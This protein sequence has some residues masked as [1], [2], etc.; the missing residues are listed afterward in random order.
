[1]NTERVIEVGDRQQEVLSNSSN[2][3]LM[4]PTQQS[5]NQIALQSLVENGNKRK[6]NIQA[7]K[8]KVSIW[9]RDP[10][11]MFNKFDQRRDEITFN[12]IIQI[13]KKPPEQRQ[14][15]EIFKLE[16]YF[17]NNLF[18]KN[19][20][21][22]TDKET[23]YHCYK[24]MN[25][26]IFQPGET[27]FYYGDIG[28]LFYIILRGEVA[29]KIPTA[30]DLEISPD[31]LFIFCIQYYDDIEWQKF[32]SSENIRSEIKSEINRFGINY[33]NIKEKILMIQD[34]MRKKEFQIPF[35]INELL[36]GKKL[37]TVKVWIFKE[38]ST[39][40]EG[41]SFG[42]LALMTSKPRAA[43]IQCKKETDLAILDKREYQVI[44]GNA[45]KRQVNEKVKFFKN[46]RIF[47][48]LSKNKMQR[49]LYFFNEKT[50]LRK[51]VVYM[52]DIDN[53]DGVYF[54]KSGEFEVSKKVKIEKPEN[55]SSVVNQ[56][57]NVNKMLKD[58]MKLNFQQFLQVD[59]SLKQIRLY[60]QGSNEIFGLEEVA[61]NKQKRQ[62][63]VVCSTN[64][65]VVYFIKREDFVNSVNLF[66]FSDKILQEKFIKQQ[67]MLLRMSETEAF[68][69]VKEEEYEV[70]RKQKILEKESEKTMTIKV[71]EEF[72][73]KQF[74]NVTKK[75]I[76]DKKTLNFSPTLLNKK[77]K[78]IRIK[79]EIERME[80]AQ[81]THDGFVLSNQDDNQRR[82]QRSESPIG[83]NTP[84]SMHDS[85]QEINN[86]LHINRN[87][88]N[89]SLKQNSN[90]QKDFA[91]RDNKIKIQNQKS[92]KEGIVNMQ[93]ESA[94]ASTKLG[95]PQPKGSN[96]MSKQGS[97]KKMK[98]AK[99][100]GTLMKTQSYGPSGTMQKAN[101]RV[102]E[103]E[104]NYFQIQSLPINDQFSE[105]N[106]HF[107]IP[108]HL[109]L[110]QNNYKAHKQ[111]TW[112]DRPLVQI[113]R[114]LKTS[115]IT[116]HHSKKQSLIGQQSQELLNNVPQTETQS[117]VKNISDQRI[118]HQRRSIGSLHK[119]NIPSQWLNQRST[120]LKKQIES[121]QQELLPTVSPQ[122]TIQASST[123]STPFRS[124]NIMILSAQHH[125]EDCKTCVFCRKQASRQL[126]Q[127]PITRQEVI[128]KAEKEKIMKFRENLSKKFKQNTVREQQE[129][130]NKIYMDINLY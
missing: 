67:L 60:L 76:S 56:L 109:N 90:L 12:D 24:I 127:R 84:Q 73:Q 27:I 115:Q 128:K 68:R 35:A 52:E 44:V 28:S 21:K 6:S 23:T 13:L 92:V 7:R 111:Q 86:N 18:F 41:Q 9:D 82:A 37:G 72:H 57:Q 123:M 46:F 98:T 94:I 19:L 126:I 119:N 91:G 47:Q 93:I 105:T 120:P 121:L 45:M 16:D 3:K 34:K 79:G 26:Q 77:L 71:K 61:D 112:M 95:S 32:P 53:T 5:Q 107:N 54:I 78:F 99:S 17:V 25:Y 31:D 103:L 59:I 110:V 33:T 106:T 83:L 117:P 85:L 10:Q 43:T 66:K 55:K 104:E 4:S 75:L 63:T 50:Y 1:M 39:L 89:Q 96:K 14:K 102:T 42:E 40:K 118:I 8:S 64:N 113:R 101:D 49:M 58:S 125:P 87:N 22:D 116:A 62:T 65:A 129:D 70:N 130:F 51:Q 15:K 36:D 100:S 69:H 88:S 74:Q 38:V 97:K 48:N 122:R 81:M 20:V 124:S 114:R 80:R 108:Q 29:V 11:E 30:L 2:S